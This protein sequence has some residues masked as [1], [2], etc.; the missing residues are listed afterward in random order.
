MIEYD[1]IWY[2]MVWWQADE[3]YV[4]IRAPLDRLM[5]EADRVDMKLPLNPDMLRRVLKTGR[6]SRGQVGLSVCMYIC[7][8]EC[9]Y[10]VYCIN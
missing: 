9:E 3:V 6:V 10:G 1:L 7:M 2:G 5:R 4:K 8:C